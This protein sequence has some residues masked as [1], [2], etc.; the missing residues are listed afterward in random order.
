MSWAAL[1][2]AEVR[3]WHS[4]LESA[5]FGLDVGRVVVGYGTPADVAEARLREE[6][7][8]SSDELVIARWPAAFTRLGAVAADVEEIGWHGAPST[9]SKTANLH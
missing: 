6:L 9:G 1:T 5:R 2:G 8:A 3:A 7:L 4:P